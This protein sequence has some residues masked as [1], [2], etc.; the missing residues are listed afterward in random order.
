[1]ILILCGKKMIF[2]WYDFDI[3]PQNQKIWFDFDFCLSKIK[4]NDL[5]L[6]S[7]SQNHL[8]LIWFCILKIGWF[9]F[10]LITQNIKII[11]TL[12][13]SLKP[14]NL[15]SPGCK[16]RQIKSNFG[17]FLYAPMFWNLANLWS[18]VLSFV[19][20][21]SDKWWRLMEQ[22]KLPNSG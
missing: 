1:M 9:W 13:Y 4:N 6:I 15:F 2:K 16:S 22:W 8:I 14:I 5:I 17:I 7:K 19:W 10:D 12:V 21:W 18:L 11:P 20:K 3:F